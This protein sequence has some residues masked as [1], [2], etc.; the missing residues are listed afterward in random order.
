MSIEDY[1]VDI[2]FEYNESTADVYTQDTDLGFSKGINNLYQAIQ[3]RLLTPLGR[4]PLQPTYGSLLH[5]LV[6]Q[7]N[8]PLIEMSVKMMIFEALQP[9]DRIAFIKGISVSFERTT[10]TITAIVEI[11][12]TYSNQ[13]TINATI[14]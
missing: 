6:G 3:N 13:I 8:N 2:G 12:S 10:G 4:Y 7:G 5:T 14:G 11:V 9:E 1:G